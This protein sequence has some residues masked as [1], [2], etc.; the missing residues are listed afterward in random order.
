MGVLWVC[1]GDTSEIRGY[2]DREDS[3]A[4]KEKKSP[5]ISKKR[6]FCLQ[7][8]KIIWIFSIFDVYLQWNCKV[9]EPD[10][11]IPARQYRRVL[12]TPQRTPCA[13]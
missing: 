1:Y 3:P 5:K 8:E 9:V 10:K 11:P 4:P 13:L 2:E 7:N 6:I 12:I